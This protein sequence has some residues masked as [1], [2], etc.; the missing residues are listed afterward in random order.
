[1]VFIKLLAVVALI[2]STAWFASDPDFEPALAVVGSIS[3]LVTAFMVEKRTLRPPQ[4]RQTVSKSSFGIQ[5]GGDVNIGDRRGD[6]D[7]R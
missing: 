3:A 2:G 6:K 4:Q 7:A 1:M 5:A